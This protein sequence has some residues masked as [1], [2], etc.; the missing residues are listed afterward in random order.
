METSAVLNGAEQVMDSSGIQVCVG[1]VDT[2]KWRR[3]RK[4]PDRKKH[5]AEISTTLYNK[6]IY[7]ILILEDIYIHK[8]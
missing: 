1:E 7:K 5:P 2:K 6:T 8:G 3:E 4:R